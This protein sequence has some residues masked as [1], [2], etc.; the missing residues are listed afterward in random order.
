MKAAV[1]DI[2]VMENGYITHDVTFEEV[3]EIE[4]PFDVNGKPI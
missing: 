1:N 2:H 4:E 3:K